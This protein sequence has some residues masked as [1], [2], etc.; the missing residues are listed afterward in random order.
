MAVKGRW[1]Y[2]L[3]TVTL[4]FYHIPN[5]LFVYPPSPTPQILYVYSYQLHRHLY[6]TSTADR[7]TNRQTD[8]Q[9]DNND[10]YTFVSI[11]RKVVLHIH[12]SSC[13]T[14]SENQY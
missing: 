2:K 4:R 1:S 8:R 10:V 13:E 9:V 12:I 14:T 3:V 6:G 11:K 5:V 7:P